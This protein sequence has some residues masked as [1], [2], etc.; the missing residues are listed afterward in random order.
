MTFSGL[1]PW[2][3]VLPWHVFL[4]IALFS[5]PISLLG[6]LH[7]NFF[8]LLALLSFFSLGEVGMP[9]GAGVK[10]NALPISRINLC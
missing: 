2:A 7:V 5:T 9:D 3:C 8:K 10:G 1:V 6:I 4:G